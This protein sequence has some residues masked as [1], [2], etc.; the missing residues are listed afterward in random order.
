MRL[1]WKAARLHAAVAVALLLAGCGGA[2]PRIPPPA[3]P[4]TAPAT[5][6][7]AEAIAGKIVFSRGRNLWVYSGSSARQLT[8]LGAAENPAWSP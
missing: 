5:P 6:T 4:T 2:I 1:G 8:N 3:Q 7:P